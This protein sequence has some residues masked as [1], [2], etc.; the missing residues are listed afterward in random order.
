MKLRKL[1]PVTKVGASPLHGSS[2]IRR[3]QSLRRPLHPSCIGKSVIHTKIGC[4]YRTSIR[5]NLHGMSENKEWRSDIGPHTSKS[6]HNRSDCLVWINF[7]TYRGHE[8]RVHCS[9]C[10]SLKIKG[11]RT[12]TCSRCCTAAREYR[13]G[14]VRR[15]IRRLDL[16]ATCPCFG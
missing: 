9:A 10:T 6:Q 15:T 12:L 4:Y 3:G 1:L 8:W 2:S 7:L 14:A 5:Q 13:F 11:R 16:K